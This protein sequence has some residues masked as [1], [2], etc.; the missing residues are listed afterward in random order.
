MSKISKNIKTVT[1]TL[2]TLLFF[3]YLFINRQTI[4]KDIEG[5]KFQFFILVIVGQ[6]FVQVFNALIL[7][8]TLEPLDVKLKNFEALKL[9]SV[10]SFVNFFTPVIGGASTKAVYLKSKYGL[11]YSTFV[12]ALYANYIV[13]FLISFSFGLAGIFLIPGALQKNVGS[14]LALIFSF[15]I[16]CSFLFIVAGHKITGLLMKLSTKN[17]LFNSVIHKITIVDKGWNNIRKDKTAVLKV[18]LW[19]VGLMASLVTIY[20]GSAASIG[21]VTDFG[22]FLVFAALASV[23]L[24]FNLTPGSI[25]IRETLYS[26]ARKITGINAQQVVAFSLV[27]RV[28]QLIVI[29]T[30]WLLFGHS[31]LKNVNLKNKSDVS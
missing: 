4:F 22:S 12:S 19:S 10:S 28:A 14:T 1:S 5:I 30:S 11:K 16:T 31:I 7:R 21:I 18:C 15:G 29:G 13:T 8:S 27:D 6:I 20:W 3:T 23:S 26:A 25:G 2:I 9:T 24:L 17:K